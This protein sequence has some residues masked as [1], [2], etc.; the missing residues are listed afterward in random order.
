[1]TS[2]CP[3]GELVRGDSEVAVANGVGDDP[4]AFLLAVGNLEAPSG[5]AGWWIDAKEAK[6]LGTEGVAA[7]RALLPTPHCQ[8]LQAMLAYPG[9][10]GA[11]LDPC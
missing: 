8:R 2:N 3:V 11:A 9:P 4:Y 10:Q 5:R 7:E 1:M 6:P